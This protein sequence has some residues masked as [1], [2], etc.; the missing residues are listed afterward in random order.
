MN[1][2][3]GV[4]EPIRA[5]RSFGTTD[6]RG[7][8]MPAFDVV[9]SVGA[10][11]ADPPHSRRG[12]G[13]SVQQGPLRRRGFEA[14]R[15]PRIVEPEEMV[16]VLAAMPIE[17]L[18]L[19]AE[20]IE[21]F[22][23]LS[24]DRIES[25]L[26]LDRRE[27]TARFGPLVARRLD[28]ALGRR[29]EPIVPV[30]AEPPIEVER[31]F[32]TP[33][34]SREGIR[35]AIQALL[36]ELCSRLRRRERGVVRLR[37]EAE[38]VDRGV[39]TIVLSIGAPNRR[40]GHLATLLEPKLDRLDAGLG[41]ERITLRVLRSGRLRHR[42]KGMGFDRIDESAPSSSR[43]RIKA[44]RGAVESNEAAC[45]LVD[46]LAARFGERSILAAH[47]VESHLPEAS[48]WGEADL[49][50][51]VPAIDWSLAQ[52]PTRLQ[53]PPE[54]VF[55]EW[56]EVAQSVHADATSADASSGGSPGVSAPVTSSGSVIASNPPDQ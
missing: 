51:G 45:E 31:V 24:V 10:A 9:A 3:V 34:V 21:G 40:P 20:S 30:R 5:T 12:D 16:A 35:L 46:A 56:H 26:P 44:G 53:D 52:R 1:Q 33:V 13:V 18:R 25:L 43:D 41:V 19:D 6:S 15:R 23:Q 27:V 29:D 2:S 8:A 50:G 55:I 22:R 47:A 36:A 7:D 48:G 37:L 28:E 49:Q 14:M 38:R 42:Q 32:A 4:S 11:T 17:A 54:P 39:E